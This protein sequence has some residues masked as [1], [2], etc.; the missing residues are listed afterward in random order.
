MQLKR[1]AIAGADA[2][3]CKGPAD[4]FHVK[5]SYAASLSGR[6]WGTGRGRCRATNEAMMSTFTAL[7]ATPAAKAGP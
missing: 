3:S 2:K 7:Q 4:R 6:G 1:A 5:H